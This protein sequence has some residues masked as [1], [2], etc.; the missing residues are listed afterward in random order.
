MHGSPS[1]LGDL[2]SQLQWPISSCQKAVQGTCLQATCAQQLAKVMMPGYQP[3]K[4][5]HGTNERWLAWKP[6]DSLRQHLLTVGSQVLIPV[7]AL[8]SSLPMR[9]FVGHRDTE[10][11]A[12]LRGVP[13]AVLS[14]ESPSHPPA[15]HLAFSWELLPR[16][17]LNATL[18]HSSEKELQSLAAALPTQ[19]CAMTSPLYK[20][21]G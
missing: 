11:L 5:I 13:Q 15:G 20:G 9:S 2:W 16:V 21:K 12:Q 19:C 6:G 8:V 7:P 18:V 4:W 3:E 1:D 14:R 17:W 10:Q